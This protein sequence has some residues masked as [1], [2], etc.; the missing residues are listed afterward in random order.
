M[1]AGRRQELADARARHLK[2][3]EL[4]ENAQEGMLSDLRGL[5]GA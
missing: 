1:I 4:L 3:I 2:R 5:C